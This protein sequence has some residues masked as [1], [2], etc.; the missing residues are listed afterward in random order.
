MMHIFVSHTMVVSLKVVLAKIEA[1]IMSVVLLISPAG[2]VNNGITVVVRGDVAI[3]IV[4]ALNFMVV[5]ATKMVVTAKVVVATKVVLRVQ[6]VEAGAYDVLRSDNFVVSM[7]VMVGAFVMQLI[8]S[9]VSELVLHFDMML[10]LFLFD[11]VL[12]LALKSVVEIVLE[13]LLVGPAAIVRLQVRK[14][15]V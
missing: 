15:F 3:I 10:E 2:V 5:V 12:V 7:E 4:M 6:R 13:E 1:L 9:H 8:V 14:S 11:L